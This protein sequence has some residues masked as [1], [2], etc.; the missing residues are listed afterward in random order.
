M[1]RLHMVI[2]GRVQGVGFRY[3]ALRRARELEVRGWVRNA[4]DGAVEVTAEGEAAALASLRE[5]LGRGPAGASVERI[6]EEWTEGRPR[7]QAFEITG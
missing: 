6:D 5:A 2:H 4:S 7:F 1:H 3:F